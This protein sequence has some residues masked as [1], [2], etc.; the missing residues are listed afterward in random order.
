MGKQRLTVVEGAQMRK[1]EF[2][3]RSHKLYVKYLRKGSELEVNVRRETREALMRKMDVH[4]EWVNLS[5]DEVEWNMLFG[6]FQP[7]MCEVV[8]LLSYSFERFKQSKVDYD[9]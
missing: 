9:S 2:L 1:I 3:M 8:T 5:G 4:A 6:L 7:V